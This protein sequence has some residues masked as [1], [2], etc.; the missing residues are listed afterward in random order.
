MKQE[1]RKLGRCPEC[2]QLWDRM[3]DDQKCPDCDIELITEWHKLY[4]NPR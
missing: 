1:K 3:D 2:G 4:E